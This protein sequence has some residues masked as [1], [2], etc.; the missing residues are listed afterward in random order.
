MYGYI[1]RR[2]LLAVP[3]LIGVSILVFAIIRFIPGDPARAIAGVNAT[4]EYIEQVRRELLLDEGLHVQYYVYFTNLLQGDLGRSTFTRRPVT[5][6][7]MERFPNTLVLSATAMIIASVIGL[8]AG[9]VSATRRYSM[10]DNISMLAALVGVAAPVFWLGVMFQILF[11]VNLGWLPSSGIGTWKHLILPALTL[12][13]AT[14][15]LIARITRSSMLEVLR[16][17][18]ITTARSKGLIERVVTYKHALKNALIPVVTVMGLQFG[19]LLGGAVLTETVFSWP[20]IGRLM[21]DSIL[22][23]DYPVVQG[24]VL[25]LAVLFVLINLVVDIIYAFL[26]PRISYGNKE[27][28]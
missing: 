12:G 23:R 27:V 10:F 13:L 14:A 15:A 17:D 19:T 2:L 26:D 28:E 1:I 8:S 4:P 16:Q 7:L 9:I 11:S 24:A 5:V 22:N 20:G 21:V 25:M 6:E 3:V 18:Y